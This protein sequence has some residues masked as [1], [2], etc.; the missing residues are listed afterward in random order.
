MSEDQ[1]IMSDPAKEKRRFDHK[2]LARKTAV[3]HQDNRRAFVTTNGCFSSKATNDPRF[4]GGETTAFQRKTAKINQ[5]LGLLGIGRE[6][7]VQRNVDAKSNDKRV[8]CFL[9]D[10]LYFLNRPRPIN[11][12]AGL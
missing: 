9:I 3:Q 10:R 7:K 12:H 2:V 4:C 8:I 11:R 1:M 5:N 6:N